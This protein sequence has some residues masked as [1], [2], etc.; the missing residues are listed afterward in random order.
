M[1][2][3]DNGGMREE[4]VQPGTVETNA[5]DI[6]PEADL[7]LDEAEVDAADPLEEIEKMIGGLDEMDPADAV[8]PLAEIA[9]KLNRELDVSR[10][11]S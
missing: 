11:Q 6:D 7:P 10:E 8:E 5:T 3:G 1:A 2:S 4:Q 9:G